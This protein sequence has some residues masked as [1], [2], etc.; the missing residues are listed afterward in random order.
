M[1]KYQPNGQFV[2]WIKNKR[3]KL[4]EINSSFEDSWANSVGKQN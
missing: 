1:K 4:E 2:F 3:C